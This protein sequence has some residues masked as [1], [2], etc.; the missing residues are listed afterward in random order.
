M[1][2][3]SDMFRDRTFNSSYLLAR[4]DLKLKPFILEKT[5][6]IIC[7]VCLRTLGE[8]P[9]GGIIEEKIKERI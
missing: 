3:D 9:E 7:C 1:P 2:S 5:F 8:V 4:H 6:A